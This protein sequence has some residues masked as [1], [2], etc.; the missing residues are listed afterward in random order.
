MKAL[1][2]E[3]ITPE[4]LPD[5]WLADSEWLLEELAKTRTQVLTI[6]FSLNNAS[7]INSVIDRLWRLENN[8]RYLLHLHRDG[9]RAFGKRAA[10]AQKRASKRAARKPTK[11]V[12]ISA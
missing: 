7:H 6:P 4:K 8:L 2:P 11:I 1:V 9:Q 3:S 5:P 12:Q 10:A